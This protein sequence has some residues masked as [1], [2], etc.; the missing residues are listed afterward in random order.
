MKPGY[1]DVGM[2]VAGIFQLHQ[3][4]VVHPVLEKLRSFRLY[5]ACRSAREVVQHR[6]VVGRERGKHAFFRTHRT[7]VQPVGIEVE[8]LAQPAAVYHLFYLTVRRMKQQDMPHHQA[9]SRALCQFHQFGRLRGGERHRFFQHNVQPFFQQFPACR[10]VKFR[11]KRNRISVVTAGNGFVHVRISLYSGI[12]LRIL[13]QPD[14]I[15]LYHC[16][17]ATQPR[18]CADVVLSPPAAADNTYFFIHK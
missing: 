8:K 18:Q 11:R 2:H 3:R 9:R 6:N 13:F 16:G 17:K 10:I 15:R 5:P 7:Q 14:G 12:L 4:T 1:V